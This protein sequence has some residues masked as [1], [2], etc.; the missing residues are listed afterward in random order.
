MN[1]LNAGFVTDAKQTY[2]F[3]RRAFALGAIQAGVGAALIGRMAW[4]AVA[5]NQRYSLLAESNRVNLTL[6]PPRR[7]WIVDATGA[8]VVTATSVL[9]IGGEVA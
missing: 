7:G 1:R 8:H 6:I 4:L 3:S 9:L 2:S 5:E